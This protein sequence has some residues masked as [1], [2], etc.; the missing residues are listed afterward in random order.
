MARNNRTSKIRKI[1][2][3]VKTVAKGSRRGSRKRSSM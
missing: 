3:K 1:A 2:N